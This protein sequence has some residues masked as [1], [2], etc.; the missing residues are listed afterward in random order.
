MRSKPIPTVA[1]LLL[2]SLLSTAA[3]R[4]SVFSQ[5]QGVV[6]DPQ[7][8]PVSGAHIALAAAHSAFTQSTESN[9]E[10]TFSFSNIPLGDYIV[11]IAHAG[12][13]TL[14]QTLTVHSDASPILH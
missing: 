3:A 13:E 12:F 10:G 8:R 14:K 4:A 7:H 11:T 6:H 5:V 1:S 2:Y 9:A